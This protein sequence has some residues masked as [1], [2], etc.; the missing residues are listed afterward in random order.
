MIARDLRLRRPAEFERVRRRG[1]SWSTPNLVLVLLPND[2]DQ[3]RYGFAVGRRVGKAVRRNLI[4]RWMREAVRREHPHLTPGH[5]IVFI[6]RGRLADPHATYHQILE[7]VRILTR[8]AGLTN[9]DATEHATD[10]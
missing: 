3:N 4:K 10:N 2:L 8:R 7:S 9:D 1:K 6:A 5:D